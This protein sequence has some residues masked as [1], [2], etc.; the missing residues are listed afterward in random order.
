MKNPKYDRMYRSDFDPTSCYP[1][2]APKKYTRKSL[3]GRP[4]FGAI[5]YHVGNFKRFQKFWVDLFGGDMI[6]LPEKDTWSSSFPV[7]DP[8]GTKPPNGSFPV[9][10]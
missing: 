10:P 6:E 2:R 8:F 4:R 3:H 1:F 9:T 5:H 7:S